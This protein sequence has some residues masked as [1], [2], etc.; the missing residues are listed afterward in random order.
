MSNRKLFYILNFGLLIAFIA[1]VAVDQK[2]EW[3]V[4]QKKYASM[5]IERLSADL[6]KAKDAEDP[7]KI[8]SQIAFFKNKP[9]EIRQIMA[10]DLGRIDRCVTCHVGMDEFANP[11]MTN[12]YKENPYKAHPGD[13]AKTH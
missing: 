7:K 8:E 12:P 6:P 10:D 2:R 1:G 13:F 5:E 9:L 4:Y 11:S 3:K